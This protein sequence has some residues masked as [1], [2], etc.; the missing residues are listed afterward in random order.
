MDTPKPA[1]TTLFEKILAIL[2]AAICLVVTILLW[3]GISSNQSMWPLPGLYLMM[4]VVLGVLGAFTFI[5]GGSLGKFI[6]WVAA[7]ALLGFSILG[8]FSVGFFYL[9]SALLF[10]VISITCDVR[11]KGPI[12]AHLAACLVGGLAL[13]AL[14]LMVASR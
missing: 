1:P 14:M 4:V 12:L 8:A 10:F 9:P 5:W 2:G 6:T 13:V 11:N 7:G 3:G